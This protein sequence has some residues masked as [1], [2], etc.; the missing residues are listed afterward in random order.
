MLERNQARI[1]GGQVMDKF[2]VKTASATLGVNDQVC[3]VDTTDGAV[4]ITL[5]N[6]EEAAGRIYSIFLITDGGNDVTIQDQDESRDWE[7][8]FTLADAD[9]G[10]VLY[11][12][13]RKWHT[14]ATSGILPGV[15]VMW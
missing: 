6:V 13:G 1:S 2:V 12:D 10:Y 3:D 11:S 5:P 7:G 9:D 4:T 8:D 14:L 15:S